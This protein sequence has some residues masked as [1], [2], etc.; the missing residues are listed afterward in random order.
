MPLLCISGTH[1]RSVVSSWLKIHDFDLTEDAVSQDAEFSEHSAQRGGNLTSPR[2]QLHHPVPEEV[3]IVV[4]VIF[5]TGNIVD[6][7][8]QMKSSTC[9]SRRLHNFLLNII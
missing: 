3:V 8:P 9:S 6:D 7:S 2:R 4:F 5:W 1:S